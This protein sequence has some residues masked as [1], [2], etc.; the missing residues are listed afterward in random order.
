M[1][2]AAFRT[3]F[4]EFASTTDYIAASVA[5]CGTIAEQLVSTDMW[6]DMRTR[7][8]HLVAAH[9]LIL[10]TFGGVATSQ[11]TSQTKQP[12]YE[13]TSYGRQFQHLSRL[14]CAGAIFT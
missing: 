1:D 11:D 13:T 9:Y 12:G 5:N 14:F 6:G 7:A 10:G 8:V 3:E 4:P 2:S